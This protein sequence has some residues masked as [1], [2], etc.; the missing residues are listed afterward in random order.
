MFW[1]ACL[2]FPPSSCSPF[3]SPAKWGG[4]VLVGLLLAATSQGPRGQTKNQAPQKNLRLL[5]RK[6]QVAW[7]GSHPDGHGKGA[8][9]AT[10]VPGADMGVG[11][12]LGGSERCW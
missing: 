4:I 9:W 10:G 2:T 11:S 5:R 7:A 6:Q 12:R 1:M 3:V 8:S